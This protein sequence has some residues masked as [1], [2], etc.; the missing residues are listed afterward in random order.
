MLTVV[1]VFIQ[2]YENAELSNDLDAGTCWRFGR[3]GR[4]DST[5][6]RSDVP[7]LRAALAI[8]RLLDI[9]HSRNGHY[10]FKK[11]FFLYRIH[12]GMKQ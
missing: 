12:T 1:S 10:T 8:E 3:M 5:A 7:P 2:D 6:L 4:P 11:I 9:S